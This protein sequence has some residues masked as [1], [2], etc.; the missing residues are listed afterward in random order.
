MGLIPDL[1]TSECCGHSQNKSIKF[2]NKIFSGHPDQGKENKLASHFF[3]GNIYPDIFSGEI[4][5]EFQKKEFAMVIFI[6]ITLF[7]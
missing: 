7:L 6:I 4:F 1:G 3:N 2:Q 5:I